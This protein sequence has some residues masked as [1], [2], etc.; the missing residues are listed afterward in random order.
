MPSVELERPEKLVELLLGKRPVGNHDG[1]VRM[2]TA[3]DKPRDDRLARAIAAGGRA[4]DAQ[5]EPVHRAAGRKR[6]RHRS[7]LRRAVEIARQPGAQEL[8]R[9]AARVVAVVRQRQRADREHRAV[10]VRGLHP[11]RHRRAADRHRLL[12]DGRLRR[13]V[14]GVA[15]VVVQRA[16]V[17]RRRARGQ[18]DAEARE[19]GEL[20]QRT[21]KGAQR[22]GDF[23]RH[24]VERAGKTGIIRRT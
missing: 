12:L 15:G 2:P 3:R 23:L 6:H 17:I 1:L 16:P 5:L 22:I 14:D 4:R 21:K 20:S 8:E 9:R 13:Q 11:H 7:R 18:R 10:H 19:R 24:G